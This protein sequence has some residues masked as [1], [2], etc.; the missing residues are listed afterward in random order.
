MILT[1][2]LVKDILNKEVS[3]L[4]VRGGD[5]KPR[6]GYVDTRFPPQTDPP[7]RHFFVFKTQDK[8]GLVWIL[9]VETQFLKKCKDILMR[10]SDV[11]HAY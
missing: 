4:A 2:V 6:R 11:L 5:N 8:K 1:R 9:C 3:R 10:L 7:P